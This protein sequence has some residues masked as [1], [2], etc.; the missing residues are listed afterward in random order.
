MCCGRQ[1]AASLPPACSAAAFL[2]HSR[3]TLAVTRSINTYPLP[4]TV[5]HVSCP[6][7]YLS[8]DLTTPHSPALVAGSPVMQCERRVTSH[9][10]QLGRVVHAATSGAA[11][12]GVAACPGP[13]GTSS[14]PHTLTDHEGP[15]SQLCSTAAVPSCTSRLLEHRP[16]AQRAQQARVAVR[17]RQRPAVRAGTWRWMP[18]LT[19]L[20]CH[21][22]AN[23]LI[24]SIPLIIS[25][26]P[27][28]AATA[29][30]GITP[31]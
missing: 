8:L 15:A 22:S 6:C 14:Q 3:C 20:A 23:A 21:I 1:P 28:Q 19:H 13:A 5:V 7:A 27:Q 16:P 12:I 26:I 24:C 11:S 9:R 29:A 30:G 2:C 17:L 25:S 10:S 18:H 31:G 4:L